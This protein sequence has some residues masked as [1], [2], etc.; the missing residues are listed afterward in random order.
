MSTRTMASSA[1]SSPVATA[2]QRRA[3]MGEPQL[4]HRFCAFLQLD[5]VP[6]TIERRLSVS[7]PRR[8]GSQFGGVVRCDCAPRCR[9]ASTAQQLNHPTKVIGS[10]KEDKGKLKTKLPILLGSEECFCARQWLAPPMKGDFGAL[11]SGTPSGSICVSHSAIAT[12]RICSPSG[13][14]MSPTKR[15][16]DGSRNSGRCSPKNS[17][18]DA[19]AQ[20]R[21]GI[22]TK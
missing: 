21:G 7:R 6:R 16:G 20:R 5:D 15:C 10:A 22:S 12:S 1:V 11:L 9:Y 4:A 3:A 14:R 17:A 18:A 8:L 19:R 13:V 2:A